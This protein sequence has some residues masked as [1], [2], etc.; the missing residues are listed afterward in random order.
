MPGESTDTK[1][2]R[3]ALIRSLCLTAKLRAH[4]LS[5][6]ARSPAAIA[7]AARLKRLVVREFEVEYGFA[8]DLVA[9]WAVETAVR[10]NVVCRCPD[11]PGWCGKVDS[12][13]GCG[14]P[15]ANKAVNAALSLAC[16]VIREAKDGE[17]VSGECEGN[18]SCVS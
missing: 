13:C 16:G 9:R 1:R 17:S 6:V 2:L 4:V 8:P 18:C 3:A 5:P 11:R 12:D 7:V 14:S 15:E 10:L